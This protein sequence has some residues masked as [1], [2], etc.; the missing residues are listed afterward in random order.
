MV[1]NANTCNMHDGCDAIAYDIHV[2][3]NANGVS[4]PIGWSITTTSP[5]GMN[6]VTI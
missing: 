6:V 2:P 5:A 4:G 3:A 1:W